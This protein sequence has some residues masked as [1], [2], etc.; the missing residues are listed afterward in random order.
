MIKIICLVCVK[1]LCRR[2]SFDRSRP[3]SP[4][5]NLNHRNVIRTTKIH[6]LRDLH[7]RIVLFIRNYPQTRNP[8]NRSTRKTTTNK[9]IH[10]GFWYHRRIPR[11]S[12]ELTS[13]RAYSQPNSRSINLWNWYPSPPIW[14]VWM[15][16]FRIKPPRIRLP[17]TSICL[18]ISRRPMI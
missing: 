10:R 12:I 13:V 8:P 3:P 18:I 5:S 14:Q 9:I 6:P 15:I 7:W 1:N 16:S 2:N 11:P 4:T 17:S